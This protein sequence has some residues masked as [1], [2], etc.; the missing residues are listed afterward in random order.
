MA[1][2]FN[3]IA[4]FPSL[5][6]VEDFLDSW[7]LQKGLVYYQKGA[8]IEWT[9]EDDNCV[10]GLVQG[11]RR[12][13]YE[14]SVCFDRHGLIEAECSCP[15]AF[16]CKHVAALMFAT[17][18]SQMAQG[19]E[20][21]YKTFSAPE[22]VSTA[23]SD[24][25]SAS[26]FESGP[27]KDPSSSSISFSLYPVDSSLRGGETARSIQAVSAP[28]EQSQAIK[29]GDLP[30]ALE[31][32][33]KR[34]TSTEQISSA[35]APVRDQ[36]VIYILRA[37]QQLL[38]VDLAVARRLKAGGYGMTQPWYFPKLQ[39]SSAQ[40][41][42]ADDR[43][44]AALFA[45]G[46]RD[47][48]WCNGMVPDDAEIQELALR[49]IVATGRAFFESKD[50]PPLRLGEKRQ[51]NLSWQLQAD[52]T[53]KVVLCGDQP[54]EMFCCAMPWYIDTN[55]WETGP[56]ET[57]IKAELLQCIISAPPV[58]PSQAPLIVRHLEQLS[59]GAPLPLPK[60][61]IQVQ[62]VLVSP[63][64]KLRLTSYSANLSE[65]RNYSYPLTDA[66][67]PFD[68]IMVPRACL[69][70]DYEGK[71]FDPRSNEHRQVAG[72]SVIVSKRDRKV[73]EDC[74]NTLANLGMMKLFDHASSSYSAS[75]GYGGEHTF[76][77][78][79]AKM[80][81]WLPFL[82]QE[83]DPLIRKGWQVEIDNSFPFRTVD[84]DDGEWSAE[85][86]DDGGFWFSVELGIKVN[87]KKM[88]LL[89]L[90]LAALQAMDKNPSIAT[91]EKL[92]FEGRF[93]APMSDGRLLS[94]PFERVHFM[95]AAFVEL[96]AEKPPKAGRYR[97]SLLQAAQLAALNSASGW[98]L[99]VPPRL[100]P[101]LD[102]IGRLQ[103]VESIK[104]PRTCKAIL[105][106]YQQEGFSWLQF[107]RQFG[108]GGILADDM[109]LG[110]TVQALAHL[111]AEKAAGRL[112]RPALVVC[113]TS[114]VPNWISEASKFA[115]GLKVLSLHGPDRCERADNL[116]SADLAITTY[117]LLRH[118]FA[119]L[120]SVEWSTLI[121]D[122]AQAIKNPETTTARAAKSLKSEHRICLT[123]T[124]VENHLGELWSQFDFLMPG[125]LGAAD[126]FRKLFRYPIEECGDKEMKRVLSTRLRPFLLRRTK[127]EVAKDLP[128]KTEILQRFELSGKQRDLYE[129]VRLTMHEKV[130][131]EIAGKGF[132]KSQIVILDALLKLRQVCCHPGLLNLP[133]AKS[134]KCSAKLDLLKEMLPELIEQGRKILLF[135]QFTSMLDLIKPELD[136]LGMKYVEIRG[137]TKDRESPVLRF[138][139]GE[140]PIFLLSLKAGGTGLNLTAADTVIHYDPWWNPAVENQATDRAHRIGQEKPVFVYKL[141]AEG[142]V[143][144]KLLQM[145]ERKKAIANSIYEHDKEG[146]L[147]FDESDLELLFKPL[148]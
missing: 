92:N 122:E 44:I 119:L 147:Q 21:Q 82:Q 26:N 22:P 128:A 79:P 105:R 43:S 34:T 112:N 45:S 52:G 49:R 42:T 142:T 62:T 37:N 12:H 28:G 113:P 116:D 132:K 137:S 125:I 36:E 8:V 138:Q 72:A 124:P 95:L 25:I 18:N 117:A 5:D 74:L 78:P 108:L 30:E 64:P 7:T 103:R 48:Q 15:V 23:S 130:R 100:K 134:V 140:V 20:R 106:P 139:N 38:F 39:T 133:Q 10:A 118:D 59:G 111:C 54:I 47:H 58:E 104:P 127:E 73:E 76:A 121:L 1:D 85:L 56:L 80:A 71:Y 61:N 57:G 86:D 14:V 77:F 144:D 3:E 53:Q 143:E 2:G 115:P 87:G 65:R 29:D 40:P 89:P 66:R 24:P 84:P 148:S 97:I 146:S 136:E 6:D 75:S 69:T 109:G 51:A 145:Q 101:L 110:K 102:G 88:P 81:L 141:I 19:G 67:K 98:N 94:V 13:P 91:I 120:S 129:T 68:Q 35:S 32:W 16:N 27:A 83:L 33:L 46:R 126:T 107:L 9:H 50:N 114:V 123:G 60:T 31:A 4:Y 55:S 11:T 63:K 93:V 90:L 17:I 41:V 135:S 131:N 96:F 99:S 70:F